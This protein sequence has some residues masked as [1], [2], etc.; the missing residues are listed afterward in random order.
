MKYFSSVPQCTLYEK[1]AC[2]IVDSQ[3]VAIEKLDDRQMW[4][5]MKLRGS[6]RQD[7]ETTL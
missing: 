4:Q 1:S 7:P 6:Q 5:K 2:H 3:E